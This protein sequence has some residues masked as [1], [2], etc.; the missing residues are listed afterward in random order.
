MTKCRFK[1]DIS[2]LCQMINEILVKQV[3]YID[4]QIES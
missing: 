3:N 1:L 2:F 4:G